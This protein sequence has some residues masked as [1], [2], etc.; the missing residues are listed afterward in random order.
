MEVTVP[1]TAKRPQQQE[2]EWPASAVDVTVPPT[3]IPRVDEASQC[4]RS[5]HDVASCVLRRSKELIDYLNINEIL[6]RML[7]PVL[8]FLTSHEIEKLEDLLETN[9][10]MQKIVRRLIE[11]IQ[12]Q[13]GEYRDTACRKLV[14]CIILTENHRGHKEL[15]KILSRKLPLYEYKSIQELVREVNDSP[16]TA[17]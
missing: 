14:A 8:T 6:S 3:K 11:F 1:P 12:R 5:P 16:L 17:H 4:V 2:L 13:E 7:T 10:P 15:H 9:T